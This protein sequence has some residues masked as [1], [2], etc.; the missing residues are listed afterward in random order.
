MTGEIQFSIQTLMPQRLLTHAAQR[1]IT[2][3][4]IYADT[5][6]TIT[7]WTMEKDKKALEE[8]LDSFSLSYT[9]TS[10]RG[11]ALLKRR[12][13]RHITL[14]A[15]LILGLCLIYLASLRIWVIDITGAP[16]DMMKDVVRIGVRPG[17]PKSRVDV[18]AVSQQLKAVYQQYSHIG[19]KL[20]GVVMK[21]SCVKAEKAP[22]VYNADAAGNVV[23]KCGGVIVS[24]DVY[25]G[26]AAVKP[27][28]TVF[29]GDI[30]IYGT[31]RADRDGT[32]VP[33][34]ASGRVIARVW[35][36]AEARISA[37]VHEKVRTGRTS[38][39]ITF[40]TPFFTRELSGE[41]AFSLYE[42]DAQTTPVVG[43][44]FPVRRIR[45]TYFECEYRYIY[46]DRDMLMKAAGESALSKARVAALPGAKETAAWSDFS[47]STD[48]TI[49]AQAVVE[50]HMEI[51]QTVQGG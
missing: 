15:G 41:N 48:S 28:D 3:L 14:A 25:H 16:A 22:D 9:I 40:E 17:T 39:K 6:G 21:I 24:V 23:A 49:A 10:V 33:V 18:N 2:A 20:S 35:T 34:N 29:E 43:L 31:E 8:L 51:S 42:E 32:T 26:Q 50:Y 30:L 27:G 19:V 47:K 36:Q 37:C 12:L 13:K 1:G 5:P 38:S 45:T 7:L 11:K 4:D 46:P 44:F